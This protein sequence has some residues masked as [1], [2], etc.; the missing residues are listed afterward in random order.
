MGETRAGAW[1][2]DAEWLA[3]PEIGAFLPMPSMPLYLWDDPDGSRYN[4]SDFATY[5]GIWRHGD[6]ISFDPAGSG[7][8]LAVPV[9]RLVQGH[10][11]A[12]VLD[13]AAID[14][15]ELIDYYTM[16]ARQRL[17]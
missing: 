17:A 4:D 7:K 9:K 6:F 13:S 12:D 14:A 2:P 15:P 5:E 1:T 16:F 3:Q 10:S 11:P 8:K